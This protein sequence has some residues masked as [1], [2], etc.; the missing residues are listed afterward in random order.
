M[1]IFHG[2]HIHK[3]LKKWIELQPKT[4]RFF[5]PG[6]TVPNLNFFF[7]KTEKNSPQTYTDIVFRSDRPKR[8]KN[9]KNRTIWYSF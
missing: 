7:K 9:R 3:K 6:Q 1:L 2:T 4:T 5:Q 8:T